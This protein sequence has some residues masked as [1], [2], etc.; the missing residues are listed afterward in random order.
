MK[1]EFLV[2]VGPLKYYMSPLESSY[3]KR[4]ILDY[5]F[6]VAVSAKS[7]VSVEA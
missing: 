3:F 6:A 4:V 2:L 1:I 5:T 7:A